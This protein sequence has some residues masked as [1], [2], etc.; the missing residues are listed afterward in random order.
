[1]T[2][3]LNRDPSHHAVVPVFLVL[4]ALWLPT[5]SAA[6]PP[7]TGKGVHYIYLIRHGAYDRV[8]SLDDRTANGLNALGREQAQLLGAR[9]AALP[10]KLTSVVTSNYTRARDTAREIGALL[11][12]S[13]LEDSLLHECLPRSERADLMKDASPGEMAD[14]ESNLENA[15]KKYMSPTPESDR[16][17]ALVC[18]GNV[19]RWF[20]SRSIGASTDRWSTMEIGNG[21]LTVVAVR[22]DG[23]TRLVMFSD[24]GHLPLEKQTWLGKGAGWSGR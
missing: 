14:C 16:I 22:P 5:P 3:P 17:D 2:L 11:G 21:S 18:H 12:V 20:V 1:M 4:L 19:I 23:S 10:V 15:W 6:D 7:V 9:L 24:V 8:D 13:P